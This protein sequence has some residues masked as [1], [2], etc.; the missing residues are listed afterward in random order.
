VE[1]QVCIVIPSC[2]GVKKVLHITRQMQRWPF[3][4]ACKCTRHLNGASKYLV[5]R[6]TSTAP[7][8]IWWFGGG[9]L[10]CAKQLVVVRT[11]VATLMPPCETLWLV[12]VQFGV[13][14]HAILKNPY[15]LPVHFYE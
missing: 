2:I 1:Q 9:W 5:F 6:G 14:S 15:V 12:C 13:V 4:S 8:N 10:A 7:R 3:G 11:A